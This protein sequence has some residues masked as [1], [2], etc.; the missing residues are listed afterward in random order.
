MRPSSTIEATTSEAPHE[1]DLRI[2]IILSALMSFASISVD[3]YLPALPTLVVDLHADMARIELTVSTFLIGFSLGQLFWGPISDTYGR[4]RPI[5]IGLLLFILGSVGCAM[6]ATASQMLIWRVVQA[7]GAC[8]GP[9]LARAMVRDLYARERSAHMLSVLILMMAAAPLIGPLLGGQII[10]FWTWRVIFWV[11]TALGLATLFALKLLP[12]TLPPAK[13][14]NASLGYTL[15]A[16][17][18]LAFNGKLLVYAVSG[19]FYYGGCYAFIA[20]TPFAYVDYYQLSPRYY[21]LIFGANIIGLMGVNY[22]NTR[23]LRRF[24]ANEIFRFGTWIAAGSGIALAV[25][26][27]FGWGGL[28]GLAL[29][30][31]CYMSVSGLIVANSVASALAAFPKQA[32]SVSSLVGAMHYGS[33]V[34]SAAMLG[35]FADGTPWTMGWIVAAA[36]IGCLLT[37]MLQTRRGPRGTAERTGTLQSV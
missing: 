9:V 26:A 13:R 28:A 22:F 11:L 30:I 23:L 3:M 24:R 4:R 31:F 37:A 2:L 5:A 8:A 18:Q 33:G 25:N 29:P 16:Y 1:H 12:E 35:W 17:L 15:R 21:G 34:F 10:H 14:S 32:G 20:G 19:G 27:Y 7:L 36:G 6:S